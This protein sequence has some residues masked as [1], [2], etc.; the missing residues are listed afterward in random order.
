MNIYIGNLAPDVTDQ[1]LE[2]EFSKYGKVSSAKVIKDMFSQVSKGFGFVEMAGK[3]EAQT[4]INELNTAELKG[5][6]IIVNEAR[7][8]RD[9]RR[10][11]RRF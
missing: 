10:G 4:A 6:R 11:G 3:N 5:K 8:K 9:N 1:D 7:P 2:N